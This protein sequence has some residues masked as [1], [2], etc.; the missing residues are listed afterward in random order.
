[1][2]KVSIALGIC[3]LMVIVMLLN[4]FQ[5]L[6][7]PSR[8]SELIIINPQELIQLRANCV[9]TQHHGR[10]TEQGGVC[11]STSHDVTSTM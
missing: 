2:R 4:P 9:P 8:I 5:W 7:L 10:S 11:Y 3:Q 1:M 6:I